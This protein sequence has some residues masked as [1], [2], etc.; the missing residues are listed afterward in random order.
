MKR[1]KPE[2]ANEETVQL[3]RGRRQRS[4]TKPESTTMDASTAAGG[5]TSVVDTTQIVIAVDLQPEAEKLTVVGGD[6]SEEAVKSTSIEGLS[7]L[8]SEKDNSVDNNQ[9]ESLKGS[10]SDLVLNVE[11]EE[12]VVPVTSVSGQSELSLS[13]TFITIET[14]DGLSTEKIPFLQF[15]SNMVVDP[16]SGNLK[17]DLTQLLSSTSASGSSAPESKNSVQVVERLSSGSAGAASAEAAQ[18]QVVVKVQDSA[19]PQVSLESAQ[20]TPAEPVKV[21]KVGRGRPRKYPLKPGAPSQAKAPVVKT[22]FK[23]SPRR[24]GRTPAKNTRFGDDFVDST[25][26]GK[27]TTTPWNTQLM[28]LALAA[29]RHENKPFKS[30]SPSQT[31]SSVE[32]AKNGI[33]E[34]DAE[35][36][37][38][39]ENKKLKSTD[40]TD[41]STEK[42]SDT[43]KDSQKRYICA[44]EDVSKETSFT[45]T[46]EKK[47]GG[48]ASIR[49]PKTL[50]KYAGVNPVVHR[51]L[52][53]A[54]SFAVSS[55]KSWLHEDCIPAE[56]ISVNSRNPI[57]YT[58]ME[59]KLPPTGDGLLV[60]KSNDGL[61]F[62]IAKIRGKPPSKSLVPLNALEDSYPQDR[63]FSCDLCPGFFPSSSSWLQHNNTVHQRSVEAFESL[64]K[65]ENNKEVYQCTSCGQKFPHQFMLAI[66]TKRRRHNDGKSFRCTLC[67]LNFA[68]PK[69]REE[70]WMMAHPAR[71]CGLCG[72]QFTNI[73]MLRRHINNSC[74]GARF[75]KRL[76][77]GE[78]TDNVEVSAGQEGTVM[79]TATSEDLQQQEKSADVE[80]DEYEEEMEET[81]VEAEENGGDVY[82]GESVKSKLETVK[83]SCE[84]CGAEFSTHSGLWH[85]KLDVHRQYFPAGYAEKL[86]ERL[87]KNR[88]T[89]LNSHVID[90]M[91]AENKGNKFFVLMQPKWPTSKPKIVVSVDN[92]EFLFKT[93]DQA[94]SEEENLEPEPSPK[95]P[96]IPYK[97]KETTFQCTQCSATFNFASNYREHRSRVHGEC[98]ETVRLLG[99][100]QCTHCSDTFP[101][102]FMLEEHLKKHKGRRLLPCTL[103]GLDFHKIQERRQHWKTVH[104]GIGCPNCGKMYASIKYLQKHIALNC[105]DHFPATKKF[106]EFRKRQHNDFEM[107]KNEKRVE[108]KIIRCHLC[109]KLSSSVHGWRRHMSKCHEDAGF[110][111]LSNTCIICNELVYGYKALEKHLLQCHAEDSG[112]PVEEENNMVEEALKK[113]KVDIST[114]RKAGVNSKDIV[115]DQEGNYRCPMCPKTHTDIKALQ[116]HIKTHVNMNLE[117]GVCQKTFKNPTLLKQHVQRHRTDAVYSCETCLK[118]FMTLQK[119]N[120]H[121]KVHHQGQQFTCELCGMSFAQNDYLQK[122]LRCHTDKR[123]HVC[124]VCGK[125]FRTKP[126]LRVHILIH[127]RET[128]FKCQYC[129]RGFS[130][131]GNYRIHLAQHTGEKPYQCDQCDISFALY[132][133]LK[134][135]KSTHDQKINYRCIWC[136]KECTQRKHMQMHVQRVHKEDFFQY[137]EQMKLETPLPIAPSQI[138]LYNRKL[139]K[140]V[141]FRKPYRTRAQKCDSTIQELM[142]VSKTE[143]EDV[144]ETEVQQDQNVVI[145]PLVEPMIET[146][147][148]SSALPVISSQTLPGLPVVATDNGNF[149]ILV[150]GDHQNYVKHNIGPELIDQ[151][152]TSNLE[153]VMGENNE[154][155]IIIKD[156]RAIQDI[157][158]DDTT[159]ASLQESGVSLQTIAQPVEVLVNAKVDDS[160]V[161]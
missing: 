63:Y 16:N 77:M 5:A 66:H 102:Q 9:L 30:V 73:V 152:G 45:V 103:C 71:S 151:D 91:K 131:K 57:Y 153:I 117:C 114:Y 96:E 31:S 3:R 133:H 4:V 120:K 88:S 121:R 19:P 38:G 69:E 111:K 11:E 6:V 154:I 18:P 123:P 85:H 105:Q 59:P 122:H 40:L 113:C 141:K 48:A 115:V 140:A 67:K 12:K 24:S 55:T 130:Q 150:S 86:Q 46:A 51:T 35:R 143:P 94:A 149:E 22:D 44:V 159:L 101:C 81:E 76:T 100:F 36:G 139:G 33:V 137:E 125:T 75:R 21:K 39:S 41:E 83:V 118:K 109:P 142:S 82:L 80:Y 74:H 61:R 90:P 135:H 72:K 29:E 138:K 126:E 23:Q 155:N 53:D 17:V 158:G 84:L 54:L 160:E 93:K 132:C 32:L 136:G 60:H 43:K 128:P 62:Q 2:Q 106:L 52:E 87:Q 58:I 112:L 64:H 157:V 95:N 124:S 119:L 13:E 92:K 156:P 110:S 99:A 37:V 89:L 25:T 8:A 97:K 26:L 108:K 147:T 145:E 68:G 1:S 47:K 148:V 161:V 98:F 144:V 134:R 42:N 78:P 70:H 146:V 56:E 14:K 34:V 129:G 116:T 49:G 65:T 7:H 107:E 28:T 15:M 50:K 127:T 10:V 20:E 79:V 104:P 27:I